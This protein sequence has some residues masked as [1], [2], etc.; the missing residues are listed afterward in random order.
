MT[1]D[2]LSKPERPAI[3]EALRLAYAE[4][5]KP[6]EADAPP[7]STFPMTP[8]AREARRM[9]KANPW[10]GERTRGTGRPPAA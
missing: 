8:G 3:R 1:G 4:P 5:R 2:P 7:P 10:R 9:D 6:T